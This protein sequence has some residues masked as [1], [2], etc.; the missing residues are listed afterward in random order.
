[1]KCIVAGAFIAC[2]MAAPVEAFADWPADKPI[3]LIEPYGPGTALDAQTRYLANQLTT[4]LKATIVIENRAGANGVMGSDAVAR[5]APDG[6][7]FLVTGPGIF[8]NQYLMG[9]IPF[10][11]IKDFVP[12]AKLASVALVLAVPESSPVRS[13]QDLVDL[14]RRNPGKLTYASGG[15]GSSQHLAATAF[16]KA[17]AID[18][19]HVPYK[20]QTQALT[21]TIGGQVD[22]AFVA[23]ATASGS[24]KAGRL[25]P[26][27]VTGLRRSQSMPELPT[28]AESGIANYRFFSF[29][30]VFAPAGTPEAVVRRFSAALAKGVGTTG[31]TELLRNEG[32]EYDFANAREWA[33]AIPAEQAWWKKVILDSGATAQ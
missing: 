18:V 23:I 28:M 8:T 27:A 21:D 5:A 15:N 6:Y 31:F 11:P 16:A 24:F 19:L 12:V 22:F 17:A 10:D 20:T 13:V 14:A 7:T 2:A 9:K 1:M 33:D 25:R 29:T 26:L 4:E 30:A 32:I 3:T